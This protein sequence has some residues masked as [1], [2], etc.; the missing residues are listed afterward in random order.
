MLILKQAA[1]A[2][3]DRSRGIILPHPATEARKERA[4]ILLAE[5]N[6]VNQLLALSVLARSGYRADAV[7]NGHEAI[8]ALRKIPYDL[9]LMDCQMPELDG[10]EATRY[11]RSGQEAAIDPNVPIIALTAHAMK[12]DRE[13]CLEAGMNDFVGKPFRPQE[14]DEVITRWL[15]LGQGLIPPEDLS[16]EGLDAA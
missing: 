4:R 15:F 11:I 2:A 3:V 6:S 7:G 12:D 13:R 16:S 10:L 8:D 1:V 9:V 14:L 5:D